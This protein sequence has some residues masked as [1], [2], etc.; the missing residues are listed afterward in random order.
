MTDGKLRVIRREDMIVV[1]INC[2]TSIDLFDLAS[3]QFIG[4]HMSLTVINK[5]PAILCPVG[6]FDNAIKFLEDVSDSSVY[7][8][9]FQNAERVALCYPLS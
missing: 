1:A 8:N 3:C 6:R 5:I 7:I 2:K 4:K 9:R